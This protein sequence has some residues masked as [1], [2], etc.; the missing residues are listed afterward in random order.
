[1]FSNTHISR[2]TKPVIRGVALGL[3]LLGTSAQSEPNAQL[4]RI[5]DQAR[6]HNIPLPDYFKN[7]ICAVWP[8]APGCDLPAC[9]PYCLSQPQRSL[10]AIAPKLEKRVEKAGIS[11]RTTRNQLTL[12]AKAGRGLTINLATA[13]K[14]GRKVIKYSATANGKRYSW[15]LSYDPAS[16]TVNVPSKRDARIF[17]RFIQET[18]PGYVPEI[19][20]IASNTPPPGTAIYD[21]TRD[22]VFCGVMGILTGSANPV[23]GAGIYALCEWFASNGL[24]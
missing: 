1:M 17:R 12:Q 7:P 2:A 10:T 14:A 22:R 11:V 20:R 21:G 9:P 15:T 4:K 5:A 3:A 8:T 6:M 16:D 23:A 18:S 19:K 24:D 13:Q